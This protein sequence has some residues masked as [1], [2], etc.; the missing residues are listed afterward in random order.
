MAEEAG[1]KGRSVARGRRPS[2]TESA[3]VASG[4]R[5]LIGEHSLV[6][7]Y[8]VRKERRQERVDVE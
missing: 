3:K 4:D 1:V 2:W 8:Q 5:S 7:V 6:V